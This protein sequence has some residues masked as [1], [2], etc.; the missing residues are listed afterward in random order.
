M[1]LVLYSD[2]SDINHDRISDMLKTSP[3]KLQ[4]DKLSPVMSEFKS[5]RLVGRVKPG[6]ACTR[7]RPPLRL[8]RQEEK[9]RTTGTGKLPARV[10]I[11]DNYK[12]VTHVT[13]Q[14]ASATRIHLT[15]LVSAFTSSLDAIPTSSSRH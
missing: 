15:Q 1:M 8:Q 12:A 13:I 4:L 2:V 7:S 5:P 14:A 3:I 6:P 9:R 11:I 10:C